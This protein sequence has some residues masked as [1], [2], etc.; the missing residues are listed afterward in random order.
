MKIVKGDPITKYFNENITEIDFTKSLVYWKC[1]VTSKGA[2]YFIRLDKSDYILAVDSIN[3]SFKVFGIWDIPNK[4]G[5]LIHSKEITYLSNI[6]EYLAPAKMFNPISF[7][8]E[9]GENSISSK[10]LE[11]LLTLLD[12]GEYKHLS[13]E[14][15]AVKSVQLALHLNSYLDILDSTLNKKFS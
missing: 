13:N 10:S 11:I 15:I 8:L 5:Y 6:V 4:T 3:S 2:L 14:E 1:N 9:S 7:K 12:S